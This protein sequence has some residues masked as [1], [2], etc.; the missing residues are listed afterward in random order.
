MLARAQ[1]TL[2]AEALSDVVD[3]SM[4]RRLQ[5]QT[6]SDSTFIPLRL[7][8]ASG[9][10]A[11]MRITVVWD[12]VVNGDSSWSG[13]N[14]RR[15]QCNVVGQDLN[16]KASSGWVDLPAGCK[17]NMVVAQGSARY[18]IMQG[19]TAAAVS[20]WSRTLAVKPVRDS[21]V[22]SSQ[23]VS[24]EFGIALGTA[25]IN[26]D[27][28]LIMTARP[29]PNSPIA[30]FALCY[31]RDQRGRCTI[32]NFNWVPEVLNA[33]NTAST[34]V[35]EAE[36]HTALHE[37]MHVLGGMA[38]GTDADESV[39]LDD[40]GASVGG[41]A[42]FLVEDDPAY[43]ASVA[44][45]M[46][47]GGMT[48]TKKRT[49]IVTPKVR[50][51]TRKWTGCA[52]ARGFPLED[53][54]LGRGSH[55][56]ARVAGPEFMAYGS[57]SGQIYVSDLTLAFLEDTGQYMPVYANAGP[58]VPIGDP[59]ADDIASGRV[60]LPT[61]NTGSDTYTPPPAMSPGA[62]RW[63]IG[64]GCDFLEGHPRNWP[65][66]YT[67][68]RN[69]AY[70]CTPDGRMSAV[71]I[72]RGDW[73]SG[74]SAVSSRP[75]CG[76]YKQVRPSAPVP[77][78]Q[79]GPQC[80]A[81]NDA[82]TFIPSYFQFFS[83]D[84]AASS[85]SGASTA[86]ARSTGGFNDAMDYVPLAVG[87]WNCMYA[88]PSDNSTAS[89]WLTSGLDVSKWAS[90]FG[91]ASDM[92]NFGGQIRSGQSRCFSSSLIELTRVA[93][94]NPA[95]PQYGLCY[96][97]NCYR[98]D[99][100]QIAVKGVIG[101]RTQWYRCPAEGGPLYIPGFAGAMACPQATT[102]CRHENVTG[103]KYPEQS[104]VTEAIFWG[105]LL[106][107]CLFFAAMFLCPCARTR[108]VNCTKS[109]CGVR[110]F[111]VPVALAGLQKAQGE[112]GE[113]AGPGA[114]DYVPE[115]IPLPVCASRLLFAS[116]LLTALLGLAILG[117]TAYNIYL[118]RVFNTG[119]TML[120]LGIAVFFLSVMGICSSRARAAHGP[121]CWVLSYFF[122]TLILVALLVWGITYNM[123]FGNYE[124]YVDRYYDILSDSVPAHVIQSLG[125]TTFSSTSTNATS[126][127]T[128][129][130]GT[131]SRAD[132]VSSVAS[133]LRR[134]FTAVLGL[135]LGVLGVFVIDLVAAGRIITLRTL[136]A[137]T[138][139]FLNHCNMILGLIL[140]T[141]GWY[142]YAQGVSTGTMV[143]LIIAVGGVYVAVSALGHVSVF[144]K[145]ITVHIAFML[146]SLAL[147]GLTAAA[148]FFCFFEAE[149]VVGYVNRQDD[150]QLGAM[151]TAI[152]VP[153]TKTNIIAS[154]QANA[155]QIGIALAV[156]LALQLLLL[157]N[158]GLL[159]LSFKHWYGEDG[160]D[161][162]GTDLPDQ[163]KKEEARQASRRFFN[164]PQQQH[165]AAAVG[166]GKE[167][168]WVPAAG[169]VPGPS[170]ASSSAAAGGGGG[171]VRGAV[172]VH[173]PRV[174]SGAPPTAAQYRPEAQAVLM[175]DNRM[176]RTG[177]GAGAPASSPAAGRAGTKSVPASAP[178]ASAAA[179]LSRP[180]SIAPPA[181]VK[182]PRVLR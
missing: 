111:E 72:I 16:A 168:K 125:I 37:I 109:C 172:V 160:K 176:A 32:G 46:R 165:G 127:S 129:T 2:A 171:G 180:V 170:S 51:V 166:Q 74:T 130:G 118:A 90:F 28:V 143:S 141:V 97:S 108:T 163:G 154:L 100:L 67:C 103:I 21:I 147:D 138:V 70:T 153:M 117:V 53:V 155:R 18:T 31:Q 43:N 68:S 29:S 128:S 65:S 92:D 63:G 8:H 145:S 179:A 121:S 101:G 116:N 148:S 60:T 30:G 93:T 107:G 49:L 182:Q 36:L 54:P 94:L 99:Y 26:T 55:W 10:T 39:F 79:R 137:L 167:G 91:V 82:G 115:P 38:P 57:G 181:G 175:Q 24:D 164:P 120:C 140:S 76:D 156:V 124:A 6:Y 33:D 112:A 47:A 27:L 75:T 62:L 20:Y 22:V 80:D 3:E 84:A 52:S 174:L 177:P 41:D 158:A 61:A 113:D 132:I 86:T 159:I 161:C 71:C 42:V 173:P 9:G 23:A 142:L 105:V 50:E 119:I 150:K 59:L 87:Y 95:F 44:A 104:I 83:S 17:A 12:V 40:T 157:L 151:A 81:E 110:L 5:S 85:A 114:V 178:S 4:R 88:K 35:I 73:G 98:P 135:G 169:T 162:W 152:G 146:L 96:R 25:Y 102:F 69:R 133:Y 34:D 45:A 56:E 106:C 19:R 11:P 58:I 89:G 131:Q 78:T 14:G 126:T 66:T 1:Q 122:I 139:V 13:S 7:V 149:S 144:R 136:N 48:R 77:G 15:R 134:N 64:E 123:A